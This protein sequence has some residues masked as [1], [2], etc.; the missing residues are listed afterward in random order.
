MRFDFGWPFGRGRVRQKGFS[1]CQSGDEVMW[2]RDPVVLEPW[3]QS[4]LARGGLG[5]TVFSMLENTSC[6]RS[7][8]S[9]WTD[10]SHVLRSSG[11]LSTLT[12]R[13]HFDFEKD[14]LNMWQCTRKK[15]LKLLL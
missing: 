13:R 3:I 15:G 5:Y 6:R 14:S 1:V 4:R 8:G 2:R 12:Y 10:I 11:L 9:S 7:G